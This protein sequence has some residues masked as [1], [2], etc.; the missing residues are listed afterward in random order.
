M[1]LGSAFLS[2]TAVSLLAGCTTADEKRR[3][4]NV[5]IAKQKIAEATRPD[6]GLFMGFCPG[7]PVLNKEAKLLPKNETI[8][9]EFSR[10]AKSLDVS[11]S[12]DEI[13]QAYVSEV[14]FSS[15]PKTYFKTHCWTGEILLSALVGDLKHPNRTWTILHS[16]S[17]RRTPDLP[18]NG[19]RKCAYA[20]DPNAWTYETCPS[21]EEGPN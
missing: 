2:L 6:G 18:T 10:F 21:K 16:S 5:H 19:D 14:S 13:L 17:D 3:S 1:H 20:D 9:A 15:E 12:S 11:Q 4:S 7:P 8:A